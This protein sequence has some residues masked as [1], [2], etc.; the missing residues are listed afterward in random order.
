LETQYQLHHMRPNDATSKHKPITFRNERRGYIEGDSLLTDPVLWEGFLGL[1]LSNLEI[2]SFWIEQVWPDPTWNFSKVLKTVPIGHSYQS[3]SE[4]RSTMLTRT[5]KRTRCVR[6]SAKA[7]VASLSL[8]LARSSK[9]Y[10]W[11]PLLVLRW[12]AVESLM[13]IAC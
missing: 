9:S 1:C 7:S 6:L 11:L 2:L 12:L 3:Y 10:V 13:L 4:R 8:R 5:F